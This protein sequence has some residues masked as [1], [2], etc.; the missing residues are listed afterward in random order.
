MSNF[1]IS[2][3]IP[4]QALQSIMSMTTVGYLEGVDNNVLVSH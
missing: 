1:S 2:A 3:R 4:A